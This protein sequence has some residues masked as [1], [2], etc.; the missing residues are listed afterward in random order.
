LVLVHGRRADHAGHQTEVRGESVVESVHD[1]AKE[2]A[3]RRLVPR[4][5]T[6]ARDLAERCRV[7]S[8][9]AGEYERL[10]TARRSERRLAMHVEVRSD[11]ASLF[12]EEHRQ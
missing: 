4:L 12:L 6:L 3:G 8:R 1:V 9:F 5:P 2:S 10:G 7:G 11:L